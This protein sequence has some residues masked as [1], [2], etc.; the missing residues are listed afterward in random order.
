MAERGYLRLA[1]PTELGGLGASMRQVVL[2]RGGARQLVRRLGA[3]RGDAPVPHAWC[4]A[5]GGAAAQPDAEGVLR[6]VADDGLILATSGGSDWVCPST[7]RDARS[8][9]ATGSTGRKT[10]CT[11]SPAAGVISTSAVL[12]EPGP[13][14]IVLHAGVPLSAPG[15]SIVET[16]DTLG[17]RGT[18]SHDVVFDDVFLP[19]EKVDG[20][21]PVRGAR[22]ATARGGDP[23]RPRGRCRVP[24]AW[25]AGRATRPSALTRRRGDASPPLPSG[26]SGRCVPGCGWRAGRCSVPWTR[27]ARPAPPTRPRSP[28]VMT[29]KRHAVTEAR[30]VVDRALEVAGGRGVLPD[31]AAG[32]GVPRRARR[33]VPPAD[34]GGDPRAAR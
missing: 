29:A 3:S 28:T 8:T 21:S 4:R 25:P 16:W 6:R 11:Q 23:L 30:A 10:F 31:L 2:A 5:G 14:A 20:D 15:V 19:A 12:G 26:G 24:R 33:P 17:M 18:A 1:V 13:D 32:A 34:P 27:S 7:T 22:R 9:A